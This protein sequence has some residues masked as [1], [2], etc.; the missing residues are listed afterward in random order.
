MK[1][2]IVTTVR[3]AIALALATLTAA[4]LAA[5][6]SAGDVRQVVLPD[7]TLT[8]YK[9][10]V[11]DGH[12]MKWGTPVAGSGATVTYAVVDS[13]ADLRRR[14]QLPGHRAA[15]RPARGQRHRPLYLRRELAAAFAAWS[16]VANIRFRRSD[17]PDADIL[18]GA[19][20]APTGRAFTNVV[21]AD[22]DIVAVRAP[23]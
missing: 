9:K 3:A 8:G 12:T 16:E 21:Y 4:A 14:P 15:R 13:D 6:A 11:L 17:W 7:H 2:S 19:A 20:G 22:P 1:R 5:P 23:A 10:I 18:I